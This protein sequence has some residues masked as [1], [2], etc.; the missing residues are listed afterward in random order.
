MNTIIKIAILDD[1]QQVALST[2][3]W[4]AIQQQAAVTVFT[5]HLP[6]A[7]AVIERLLP[8]NIIC[9]M[10]ERTP[11]TK[12]ILLALPNLKLIVSTGKRNASIDLSACEELN[13][14][15]KNTGYVESGAPEHTW[16]L[17]MAAARNIVTENGNFKNGKW[18]STIGVDLKGKTIGIVG[19]GRIGK[20]MAAYAKAFDMEVIAWSQN[21]TPEN[22]AEAGAKWVT[23]EELFSQADFVT[24]HLVLSDRSRGIIDAAALAL[25]KPTAML[26]NTS[27]GPLIDE[28]ALIDTL[29]NKRIAQAILDVFNTEPLPADHALRQLDNVLATP[30]IGYVT[31][32]TYRV[33]YTDTVGAIEEWLGENG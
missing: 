7:D 15:V 33:F 26:I 17:L 6:N 19:L 5:D 18:Q 27:R 20:K 16:A 4:L 30:H 3:N 2:A 1:Y 25:M 8:F 28:T 21:L 23:K 10:R 14:E 22:A 29:K 11:L 31:E 13:I 32:E 12:A 24:V 9:V